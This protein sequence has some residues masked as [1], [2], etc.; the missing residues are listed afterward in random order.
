MKMLQKYILGSEYPWDQCIQDQLARYGDME[1]A[2]KVCGMIKAKYGGS[3]IHLPEE[4][5][6]MY[7][8]IEAYLNIQP[9]DA[10][11][12]LTDGG[13][14]GLLI[15]CNAIVIDPA[16]REVPTEIDALIE[17]DHGRKTRLDG[18][19]VDVVISASD[20]DAAV[21]YVKRR[22]ER[23]PN[24][25][26]VVDYEHQTLTGERAPAAGWFNDLRAITR[27]GK[28]VA[29]AI[30]E[31]WTPTA[32]KMILDGEYRY[33]SPVFG[34]NVIDK[35]TGKFEQCMLVNLG[36]TN[37]PFL[38]NI[39]PI[40]ASQ[41]FETT[42][43]KDTTMQ[44]LL[45]KLRAFLGLQDSDGED[46]IAAK[47]TEFFTTLKTAMSATAEIAAKDVIAYLGTNK[48]AIAAKADLIKAICAKD[49]GT[50]EEAKAFYV[51]L[52][53]QAE[54][55]V[56]LRT[57]LR[58]LKDASFTKDFN[59][60]IDKN[61]TAGKILPVQKND[62]NW[63]DI[64][65]ASALKDIAAFNAFWEKQPMIGPVQK[66]PTDGGGMV[67]AKGITQEDLEIGAKLNVSKETLEKYNKPASQ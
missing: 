14:A 8:E 43:R 22:R 50:I 63:M 9:T 39:M 1:T 60:I 55:A 34:Q 45:K 16:T 12:A 33:D 52:K 26:F 32:A 31:K 62:A 49:G 56:A 10:A 20:V 15:A 5:A 54:Q 58:Q 61:F 2:K 24:R 42:K 17:G 40:A 57:E 35:G 44:D 4:K 11:A 30:I 59:A 3:P 67:A 37:E 27:N 53:A 46:T 25:A 7:K 51:T 18:E 66:L 21:D 36:L 19:E 47:M 28:R 65:K 38:K 41:F 13:D 23:E 29:R 64:Q 6:K 48:D